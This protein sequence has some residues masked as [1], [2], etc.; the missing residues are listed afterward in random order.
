MS[1]RERKRPTIKGKNIVAMDCEMVGTNPNGT[2]ENMLAKVTI[3]DF[4]GNL[5]LDTYVAPISPVCDYRTRFSGV[6]A[7]HLVFA[8]KFSDV[9]EE[10]RKIIEPSILVGH[11]LRD[12]FGVLQLSH[13]KKFTRDTAEWKF[14]AETFTNH[15]RPSLKL[16]AKKV[17][18]RDIQMD[19][20]SSVIDARATLD[21]YKHFQ[22]RWEK[23][24]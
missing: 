11:S 2:E 1:K 12:D 5:I 9:Q 14:L 4:G 18:G 16:L 20:H 10:V 8:T 6:T 23:E 22:K 19:Q 17:L 24:Y 21:V 3:I 7:S 15:H 13:D